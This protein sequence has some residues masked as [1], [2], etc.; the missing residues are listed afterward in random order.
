MSALSPDQ[1]EKNRR[2]PARR[3]MLSLF[4]WIL[5]GGLALGLFLLLQSRPQDLPNSASVDQIP[6]DQTEQVASHFHAHLSIIIAGQPILIPAAI[7]IASQGCLYWLHTHTT[8][9]ILHIEAPHPLALTLGNFLDIW[10]QRFSQSAYP[11]VLDQTTG[12]QAYV[13]GKSYSGNFRAI[14]LKAHMLITLAYQSPGV[15]PDA[16]YNWAN[17]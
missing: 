3:R 10:K 17:L 4:Q 6:C 13:D 15:Q 1:H 12:W 9:G 2:R 14:T 8:D 16:V 11:S 7:G 5:L